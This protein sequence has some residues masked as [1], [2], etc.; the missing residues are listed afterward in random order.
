[1]PGQLASGSSANFPVQKIATSLRSW[2]DL[3]A[4]DNEETLL[5]GA[6][7][8]A[9]CYIMRALRDN[10]K[11]KPRILVINASPDSS[12]MYKQMMNCFFSAGKQNIPVDSLNLAAESLY[13]QQASDLTKGIYL[14]L[15]PK[16]RVAVT[17]VL[18]H[19]FL[20]DLALR[21]FLALPQQSQVDYRAICFSHHTAIDNGFVCPVCLSVFCQWK[22]MC[23]TCRT[24]FLPRAAPN[25]P[26]CNS[27]A[28]GG[29]GSSSSS[30]STGT[31]SASRVSTA[32]VSSVVPASNRPG[33]TTKM[34][35]E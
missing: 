25:A 28:G 11:V 34:E 29:G 35:M 13:L 30:G 17:A 16:Q 6:L 2:A 5:P 3:S 20:P 9:L 19:T 32:S 14:K 4:G 24:R 21:K 1:L 23:E 22:L 18:N 10:S 7:S 12:R 33:V 31:A 8:L 26:A 27:S 15:E